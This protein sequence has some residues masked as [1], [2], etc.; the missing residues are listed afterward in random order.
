MIAN[1]KTAALVICLLAIG[2]A[3]ATPGAR[4][5]E[6][7]GRTATK[8]VKPVYPEIARKGQLTGTVKLSVTVTPEGKVTGVDVI[9]GHPLF[10]VAASTAAR[11]WQFAP[12]AKQS[13]E[14]IVFDFQAPR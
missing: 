9:G 5:A 12:A 10:V 14:T 2:P 11:Q 1:L 3:S 7:Q 4:G 8:K 13:S 6:P